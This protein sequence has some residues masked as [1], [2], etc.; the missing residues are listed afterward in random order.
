MNIS[1]INTEIKAVKSHSG[2]GDVSVKVLSG[3]NL[4]KTLSKG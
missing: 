1:E 2:T 3:D 4:T